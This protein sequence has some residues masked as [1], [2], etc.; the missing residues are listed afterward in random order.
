MW[1]CPIGVQQ[2]RIEDGATNVDL[3][4]PGIEIPDLEAKLVKLIHTCI[5]NVAVT[6]IELQV[7]VGSHDPALQDCSM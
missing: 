5:L 2:R 4:R 6:T 7:C 3:I 1:N